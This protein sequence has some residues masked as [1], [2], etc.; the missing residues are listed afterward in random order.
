MSLPV[1]LTAA[2]YGT[3]AHAAGSVKFENALKACVDIKS[4]SPSTANGQLVLPTTMD[5]KQIIAECGCKSAVASYTS[6]V[7]RNGYLSLL[8]SGTF[9][10]W[11]S[12]THTLTLASDSEL[13][14][15]SGI[16]LTLG[17]APPD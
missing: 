6:Q 8:Q 2:L 14:G 3:T 1:L 5:V 4:G 13:V 17:C 15:D 16:V 10:L 9:S 12:G 11:Q 7:Q